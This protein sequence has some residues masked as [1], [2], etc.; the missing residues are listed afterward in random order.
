[1]SKRSD[2]LVPQR[3]RG[4]RNLRHSE[5]ALA[6]FLLVPAIAIVFGLIVYPS[7]R[8]VI[9]SLFDVKSVFSQ[10]PGFVGLGNYIDQL[11]TSEFWSSIART[12][13]FTAISTALELCF[14]MFL[15]LL[16]NSDRLRFR[17]LFTAIVVLPWAVPNIV[18]A[19]MWKG[20]FNG[21]YGAFNS[22]LTQLGITD[23]YHNWL[24]QP[25]SAMNSVIAADVWKNTPL[26]AIFL[27][28]G[29]TT[30]PKDLYDSA[31]VDRAG[32]LK[33]FRLIIVPMIVPALAVVLVLR[34]VEAFK[35][36]D[37]IYAMTRGGPENGTETIAY[38]AYE[39]A[40]SNQ[41][42]GAGASLAFL[43]LIAILF[44]TLMYLRLLRKSEMTLI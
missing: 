26:V 37:I 34:T 2:D 27:L 38:Y 7:F 32:W 18:N 5:A 40:F 12:V 14:G 17:W 29:L 6:W 1:M 43:I 8:T 20:I 23:T 36:F 10:N 4:L 31:R 44:V 22:L 41:N 13:Y 3:A 25:L 28:A 35:V 9:I 24:G 21:Q 33:I 16:L 15:A 42:F 11:T 30:I 19:A 39:T